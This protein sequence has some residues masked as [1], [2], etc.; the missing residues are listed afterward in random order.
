M[1][2]DRAGTPART[3]IRVPSRKA[4]EWLRELLA[5]A[6]IAVDGDAP[7]DLRVHDR[8]LATRVLAEGS[9]GLGEAYMDG[10]WDALQLDEFFARALRV[11]LQDAVRT[12]RTLPR[13]IQAAVINRGRRSRAFEIARR[14]YDHGNDLYAA[15]LDRRMTYSCAWWHDAKSLDEAQEAKLDLVCRKLDLRPGMRV[16]DIGCGWGSFAIFAAERYGVH[17]VGLTVSEPQAALARERAG[18]LPVEIRVQDYREIDES[19]DAIVSIGMFEHVA[20]RN[21]KRFFDVARR[22][23]TEDGRFVLHTIGGNTSSV[24]GDPW[25]ESYIFPNS[26]IP[27]MKQIAAAV[28]HRFVIEDVQNIGVHY[29]PTLL[30]WWRNFEDAWPSLRAK[31]GERFYRM[32]RY[33]LLSCAGSF[34]ARYNSVWQFVLS[35]RG[36]AGGYVR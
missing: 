14:H 6:G 25:I 9:L 30:A 26:L 28:E 20:H 13:L 22:C 36:I 10:W 27:S 15:M 4:M 17:V 29:D 23:L 35:P 21:Y 3:R 34:R 2:L 24:V 5:H 7:W 1:S 32:W 18:K 19:F 11:D 33:Y 12:W 31:Y 8:R 16:L